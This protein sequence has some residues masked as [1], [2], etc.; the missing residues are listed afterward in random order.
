MITQN[1]PM[2]SLRERQRA[3]RG[4]LILDAA[5]EVFAE[6]GY[7]D[8]SVDAIATRAGVAKGTVYL[9]FAS[10]EELLI[11]LLEQQIVAFLAWVEQ[12]S[13][14]PQPVR[15]SLEQ[16]FL[17]V[18]T[19]MQEKRNRVLLEENNSVGLSKNLIAKREG[20]DAHRI[21]AMERI[22]GLF[23]EGKRNGEL[24]PNVPTAIMLATL[25]SLISPSGYEQLLA[26]GQITPVEL[27]R[28]VSRIFF[29][30][31]LLSPSEHE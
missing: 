9:H 6:M 27:V 7:H 26:S 23:E 11:A 31:T 8:A 25:V 29:P 21:Q 1:Q 14:T 19:R 20:L 24:D 10:K 15:T 18:Y 30:R 4:T 13:T 22:T 3:E 5:Q 28:Y 2:Q 16:I 12:V 17:Y